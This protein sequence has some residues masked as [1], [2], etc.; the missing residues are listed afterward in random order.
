M[1]LMWLELD[2][3]LLTHFLHMI[4]MVEGFTSM[5]TYSFIPH[6]KAAGEFIRTKGM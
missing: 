2:A 5:S 6:W 4:S 3:I 1:T